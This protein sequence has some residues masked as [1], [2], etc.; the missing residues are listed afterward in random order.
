MDEAGAILWGRVTYEMMEGFWPLVAR[1]EVDATPAIREWAEHL[2]AKPKYVASRTRSE[3]PWTNS[4]HL[5]GDLWTSVQKLKDENPAGVLVGSGQLATEL[6][7][8]DLID[9][10]VFLLQ[11]RLVGR[12]PTLYQGGL[13]TTRRLELLSAQPLRCGAV[14]LRYRRAA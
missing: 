8:L 14:A 7:K 5:D 9:E 4:H 11:P 13:A 12:G 2:E 10:Y 6:E 3:F 1:N